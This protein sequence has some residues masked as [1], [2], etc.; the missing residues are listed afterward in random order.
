M[1]EGYFYQCTRGAAGQERFFA[2]E[3]T[4]GPWSNDHQHGGPPSALLLRAIEAAG[5][6]ADPQPMQLTRISVELLRPVPLAAPLEVET[7][8]LARG[9]KV[10]RIAA[11]LVSGDE[12]LAVAVAVRVRVQEIAVE[13]RSHDEGL[14][15][16]PAAGRPFEFG[17]FRHELAYHKAIELR[18]VRGEQ[19]DGSMAVWARPR[20]P[21]IE[22]ESSSVL[23]KIMICADAGHGVGMALD[24][25]R[26]SFVNPD[27]SVHLHR[28]PA[29]DWLGMEART[30]T[31]GMG[32]G[33]CRTRLLDASGEVGC[34]L[35]GQVIQ[36]VPECEPCEPNR[37]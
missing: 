30:W 6:R 17:F 35:Q 12:Q 2:G 13:V 29:G 7:E 14:L 25:S 31:G 22:G 18:A 23:E 32:I 4:R 21:L 8:I 11:A 5:N 27:L 36:Q 19:G 15:P 24:T 9:R 34:V 10:Q 16:P 26:W 1:S 28:L 37:E 33:L 20:V 3:L